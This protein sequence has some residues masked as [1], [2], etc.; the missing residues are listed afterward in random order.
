MYWQSL[1]DLCQQMKLFATHVLRHVQ[2]KEMHNRMSQ[3][4]THF[5]EKGLNPSPSCYMAINQSYEDRISFN[6]LREDISTN[7]HY[8]SPQY[9]LFNIS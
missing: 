1:E 6:I 7:T 5:L 3:L 8:I 2:N 4:Q 9:I